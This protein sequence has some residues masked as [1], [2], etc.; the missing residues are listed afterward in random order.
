MQ[1]S[2]FIGPNG[3]G[4]RPDL[5]P[6]PPATDTPQ[7][8]AARSALL[9]ADLKPRRPT[10]VVTIQ[11]DGT[12]EPT[13]WARARALGCLPPEPGKALK[14]PAGALAGA[15]LTPRER[16]G[17]APEAPETPW[18]ASLE[19]NVAGGATGSFATPLY[20]Q[21]IRLD[22]ITVVVTLAGGPGTFLQLGV[23]SSL[24]FAAPI[25][26]GLLHDTS[27]SPP[28]TWELE[29]A[30]QIINFTEP[31]NRVF[32]DPPV[33]IVAV[34]NNGA[35]IGA[36]IGTVFLHFSRINVTLAPEAELRLEATFKQLTAALNRPQPPATVYV[37]NRT[38]I[39]QTPA[40]QAYAP[41]QIYGQQPYNA[42]LKLD[43]LA[44]KLRES[45]FGV[46]HDQMLNL[47]AQAGFSNPDLAVTRAIQLATRPP[48]AQT[49]L[50]GL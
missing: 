3:Y 50:T 17:P 18:T 40:R 43:T 2:N 49:L 48:L 12:P 31:I 42:Y 41:P 26:Q 8:N 35:A 45:P 16:G 36:A 10:C 7:Q 11:D 1:L 38:I 44:Q 37:T 32:R 15:P 39:Q 14:L 27:G 23:T 25:T 21:P 34:V 28:F 24:P 9:R 46:R 19:F 5:R 29:L 6:R 13:S 22:Y 4:L 30:N 33:A 20:F 47:A